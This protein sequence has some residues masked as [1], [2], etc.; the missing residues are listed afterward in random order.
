MNYSTNDIELIERYFDNTL[1]D[2][3]SAHIADRLKSDQEFKKLFDTEKL[4]V[5]TIR[6][7]A[8]THDLQYLKQLEGSL[9][10]SN[11]NH[12]ATHWYYYA[13]AASITLFLI[14]R[15]FLPFSKETPAE[16]YADYF[17]PYPNIFE[18]TVRGQA[19]SNKRTEAFQ[20]YEQ[21]D[22]EKAARMF[23]AL[24]S[25]KQESAI[26]FLLGNSNLMLGRIEEAKQNFD[27]VIKNF[28]DMDLQAKWFL[29]LSYLKNGEKKEAIDLLKELGETEI[30]YATK[31]KELLKKVD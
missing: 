15:V 13:A 31:A 18:P 2:Q 8:A 9:K 10:Q 29:S 17:S 22:Y 26:L 14:I 1:T 3:E 5:N 20:A 11:R 4:L 7:N 21:G 12:F 6:F 24:L 25:E 19:E 27:D 28:D 16:L 30:S 23:K